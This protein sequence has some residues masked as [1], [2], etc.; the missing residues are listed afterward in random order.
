VP[1]FSILTSCFNGAKFL[2]D[3]ANSVLSQ[4]VSDWEWIVVDDNST[5]LSWNILQQ[6]KDPRIKVLHNSERIFCSSSYRRVLLEAT[7]E[8]CGILDADDGLVKNAIE[9]VQK[10]YEKHPELTYI[11]T[12]HYWCDKNLKPVRKGLSS[13]PKGSFV[14]SSLKRCRHCFSHWRTCRREIGLKYHI[15]PAGLKYAVDKYMGFALEETGTG[16]FLD[17]CL[18]YYRYHKENMSLTVPSLQKSTWRDVARVFH[19]KRL[20]NNQKAFKVKKI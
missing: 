8:I 14:E 20:A 5:D 3:C 16:G 7:G 13:I 1:K 18:Y 2:K 15:F 10:M 11:Y 4:T 17:E 19:R 6:Y 9:V 12:Q